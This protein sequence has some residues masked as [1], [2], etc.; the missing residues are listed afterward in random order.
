MAS[1]ADRPLGRLRN[2]ALLLPGALIAALVALDYTVLRQLLPPGLSH[3]ALLVVGLAGV[4]AFSVAIFARLMELHASLQQRNAALEKVSRALERD[5]AR[6]R[7][8]NQAGLALSAEIASGAVL[9]RVVDQAREVT[10]ARYAALGTFDR[11][12]MILDFLTSG[13]S[14]EERRRIGDLPKGRGLLGTLQRERRPLRLRDIEEHPDS[15]GFPAAHPSMR[16]FL[17]LPILSRGRSL[18]NLYLTEKVDAAEFDAADEE[19]LT[20]LAAQAAVAIENARLYEQVQRVAALE[21]RQRIGMDLHDGAIQSL[22]G[23]NL[24]IDD[25]LERVSGPSQARA[26]LERTS[27]LVNDVIRDLRSY[28][29]ALRG[30]ALADDRRLTEALDELVDRMRRDAGLVVDASL[31]PLAEEALERDRVDALAYVA[32]DALANVVRHS[33]AQLVRLRLARVDDKVVLEVSDD[34]VGFD[35]SAMHDGHG[36]PNMVRRVR[37]LGGDFALESA[38]GG[39]TRVSASFP[40]V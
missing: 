33:R 23:L 2:I 34:G 9:Q 11:N 6:L 36:L 35:T 27:S 32:A 7:A 26:T 40:A 24:L 4:V 22:Y 19:A 1:S 15:V 17:G 30:V 5:R 20:T 39:G 3:L 29:L 31:D 12:G 37:S 16:S 10:G 21:E 14:E 18:G 25:A 13:L 28:M 8:L 38:P